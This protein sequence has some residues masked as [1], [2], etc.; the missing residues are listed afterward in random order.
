MVQ[1]LEEL[2][3][4]YQFHF[5]FL[6]P[7]NPT[8]RLPW[9]TNVPVAKTKPAKTDVKVKE[10]PIQTVQTL[11][12]ATEAPRQGLARGFLCNRAKSTAKGPQSTAKTSSSAK[13][14]KKKA[15]GHYWDTPPHRFEFKEK[16]EIKVA[17]WSGL[18]HRG[19]VQKIGGEGVCN[20]YCLQQLASPDLAKKILQ[21]L[22]ENPALFTAEPDS[23]DKTPTFEFYPFR[24]GTWR[25]NKLREMLEDLLENRILSYIRQRFDCRFCAPSDILLRRYIPGERRSHAVHFD[26]HAYVTAVLGISNPEKYQG[27]LYIQPGP[28][29]ASR[30]YFGLEPGDLLVHSF[31]LQHGVHLWKGV[32]Y[33]VVF[34]IKDSLQAVREGT[35]PWYHGL[36]EKGDPDACYNLAQN[37]EYGLFGHQQDISKAI[38]LYERSARAGH[39][40]AQNNLALVY[41]RLHEN[42]TDPA[43]A[44]QLLHRSVEWL[45]TAAKSGFAMAQKNL[46]LAGSAMS[47]LASGR[48][49]GSIL[50]LAVLAAGTAFAW[51]NR[52]VLGGAVVASLGLPTTVAAE[53]PS[54]E[55]AALLRRAF[56]TLSKDPSRPGARDELED[57]E[58][59]LTKVIEDFETG[60]AGR[61]DRGRIRM[62][63]AQA[64]I[65]I[66]DSTG[67]KL[68]DKAEAAVEDYSEVVRLMEEDP[69]SS[70]G[71]RKG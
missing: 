3:K 25:D 71:L 12:T 33:S 27:G 52:R 36:A 61:Q 66:N 6:H 13:A 50:A 15:S 62:A 56:Q 48:R 21:Y 64:R 17:D 49:R 43:E 18:E 41:R 10:P 47:P 11:P 59:A 34:W 16:T 39:H 5:D 19:H 29:V 68:P 46:A 53:G 58:E 67:G 1:T 42:T 38:E 14:A 31:D 20:F 69:E 45:Q 23:V 63:R 44:E 30:T 37:Y 32:R 51:P 60:S 54:A 9:E 24:D 26:G 55:D 2:V 7:D 57:A 70:E 28:D 40:F 8:L 65:A 35:T 22:K 4:P